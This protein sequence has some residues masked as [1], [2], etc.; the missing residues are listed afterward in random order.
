MQNFAMRKHNLVQ[1][2]LAVNDL[3]YLAAPMVASVFL[4]DV[5]AWLELSEV[6]FVPNVKFSGASG[7]DHHFHFAIPAFQNV[8]ERI[9]RVINRPNR[10]AAESM[11]FAWM[12]TKGARGDQEAKAFAVLND[13][14]QPPM[15]TV[16]D[17]LR[18]YDITPVPW[19]RRDEV[20]KDL[21]A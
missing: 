20:R 17:A 7:Y 19:G 15:A 21:A 2:I 4:E 9:I 5:K 11:A 18:S 13:S 1:A 8:P 12:D 16:L 10:D 14:E 6:R 3:F